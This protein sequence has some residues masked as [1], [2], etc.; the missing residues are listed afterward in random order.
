MNH[1]PPRPCYPELV[2]II[3]AGIIHVILECFISQEYT[4]S[5]NLF[6]G[7]TFLGYVIWRGYQSRD[8]L[9]VWGLRLDNFWQALRIQLLYAIPAGI[10]LYVFGKYTGMAPL[11]KTFWMILAIYPI[12]GIGQQ[13]AIQNLI[14]KNLQPL[15]P[16]PIIHALVTA[17]FFSASH[18][19]N[20]PLLILVYPSGF[21]FTLIYRKYPN[22]WVVGTVHG[23]LGAMAFYFVLQKDV[24][25]ELLRYF[26]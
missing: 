18:F 4:R 19:S 22:I 16:H 17:L 12:W 15:I 1:N 9:R 23:I 14:A 25:S 24:G 2:C 11:P 3:A 26:S 20:I 13:F 21:A 7:F 6:L 8:I 10:F 5:Y